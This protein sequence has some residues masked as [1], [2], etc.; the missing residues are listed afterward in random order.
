MQPKFLK[1]FITER[2]NIERRKI[3]AEF[4]GQIERRAADRR[5]AE[6]RKIEN[7]F[8]IFERA[9]NGGG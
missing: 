3:I 7:W 6:N 1:A 8:K 5:Q 9:R 2:K 4:I